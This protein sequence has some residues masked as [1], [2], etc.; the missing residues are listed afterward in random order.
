MLKQVGPTRAPE[1][2]LKHGVIARNH[3]LRRLLGVAAMVAAAVAGTSGEAWA[4]PGCAIVTRANVAS[5]A[6]AASPDLDAEREGKLAAEGRR[7]A[8]QPWF[9]ASPTLSLSAGRRDNGQMT[10]TNAYA[11][12]SQE[13]EIAGQR[14]SRRRAAEHDVEARAAGVAAATRRVAAAALTTYF[15]AVASRDAAVIA[16]RLEG[17]GAD[18]AKVTRA[19]ADAGVASLLDAEVADAAALRLAEDRVQADKQER[20]ALA[21]LASLLGRDPVRDA[22][23]LEGSLDPLAAA[24]HVAEGASAKMATA[25]PEIRALEKEGRAHAAR[26]EAFRRARFPTLTLQLFA[27]NDGFDERVLGGGVAFPLPLPQPL[28]RTYAGEAAESEALARA[29]TSR[30]SAASRRLAN[31]LAVAL[32]SYDAARAGAA[33]YG[34]D[35]AARAERLLAEI[36]KEIEA[37]RLAV[38]DAVLAQRELVDVLRGRVEARRALALAS[39]DVLLASG[40]PL[41]GA[42]R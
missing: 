9:P 38:R 4:D 14:A 33:L 36:A 8:A 23:V 6:I 28:G 41:E 29:A 40:A 10:A 31:D 32:A 20:V 2:S 25:R 18:M 13:I 27:Q 12:L 21:A 15:Q 3:E 35:R 5:C 22:V 11:T 34:D 7:V 39:V 37:G 24:A 30:A 17:A 42:G 16:R 1:A 19:R 26:A